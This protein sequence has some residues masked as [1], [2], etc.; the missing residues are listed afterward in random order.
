MV[1]RRLNM[2]RQQL[3]AFLGDDH[4]SI[5]QFENLFSEVDTI[6]QSTVSEL[7]VRSGLALAA[8]NRHPR[9]ASFDYI[10]ITPSAPHVA[11]PARI[12]WNPVD[13]TLNIHHNS[14]VTQQVG[15][16]EYSRVT[17]LTGV[18]LAN[19]AVI[20]VSGVGS[21]GP[22]GG[23]PYIAD[24]S[25][26]SLY[27]LG[28]ATQE[29]AAGDDG[30]VT[31]RGLIHDLDTTGT[32]YG[33][34]WSVGDILYASPTVAG[35]MTNI[36]PTAPN[37]VIPVALVMV[38]DA[39]VG[40]ILCRPTVFL[41]LYYGVFY[42][43]ADQT[44][45]AINTPYE[46]TFNTTSAASGVSIGTPTSRIV[47]AHSGLYEFSFSLQVSKSS[48]AVGYL[49]AWLRKNGTDIANT[50]MRIAVQGATGENV[51]S[52]SLPQSMAAGDYLELVWAV[53]STATSLAAD[54]A[55][56]FCPAVPSVTMT[57]AQLNQ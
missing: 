11:Q 5:K 45:A 14:N 55:T 27:V 17:N 4:E 35:Q 15:L 26:P 20:G 37:L 38:E 22:V 54:A 30:F 31:V 49:W 18:A 13:D 44:A 48:A 34:S 25:S 19:G 6:T 41:Q 42:S 3:A 12:A 51:V 47:V 24:G 46:A 29:I 33:E 9:S 1:T 2:T 8:A 56:A 21:G 10:D 50:A 43:T 28:I 52:R 32:P 16:E 36:K 23:Q 53:D 7:A 39:T 57:V 40:V